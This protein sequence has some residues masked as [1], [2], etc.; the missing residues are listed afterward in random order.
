MPQILDCQVLQNSELA[1]GIFLTRFQ[2]PPIAAQA[3]P[4]QFVNIRVAEDLSPLLRRPFSVCR[5]NAADGWIEVMYRV[6]GHGTAALAGLQ[7]GE[8]RSILGPLGRGFRWSKSALREALL[9]AG[10]IGVAALPLLAERL[11]RD[12]IPV[13]LFLGARTAEELCGMEL[14][15][16]FVSETHISTDDGSRGVR[17]TVLEP[18]RAYL[19]NAEAGG[20]QIFGCGPHPMLEALVELGRSREVATQIALETL[21]GCGFGICMGCPVRRAGQAPDQPYFL[22]CIDGPVFDAREV[23]LSWPI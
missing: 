23:D 11:H 20:L 15:E 19:E 12:G 10:G 3:L 14:F 22:T 7:P 17:G 18:L 4:G 8:Q 2:A 6:V 16:P 9:V 21:M 13:R 5:S 1:P